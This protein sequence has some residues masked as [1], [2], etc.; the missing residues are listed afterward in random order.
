MP[1]HLLLL[2]T[3]L[4]R[5]VVVRSIS[6]PCWWL[7][8][9]FI[10]GPIALLSQP[11]LG[12]Y[13]HCWGVCQV[14]HPDTYP[15]EALTSSRSHGPSSAPLP[16]LGHFHAVYEPIQ[17]RFGLTPL[18]GLQGALVSFWNPV[19][20]VLVSSVGLQDLLLSGNCLTPVGPCLQSLPGFKIPSWTSA[21]LELMYDPLF[22]L[23]G[24]YLSTCLLFP[25]W[26]ILWVYLVCRR[27]FH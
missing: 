14:L 15:C 3:A 24:H 21:H 2:G 7:C 23:A 10:F 16:L 9:A 11:P 8:D 17:G 18:R 4:A 25:P 27:Y 6:I 13:S 26:F 19:C 22:K 12:S 5:P 1:T 20:L